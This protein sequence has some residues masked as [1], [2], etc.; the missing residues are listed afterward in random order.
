MEI[1]SE[2]K[3][4]PVL[5]VIKNPVAYNNNRGAGCGC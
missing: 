5:H 2:K 1:I 3:T 4:I